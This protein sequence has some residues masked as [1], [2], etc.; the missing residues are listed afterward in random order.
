M[1]NV[2]TAHNLISGSR[3]L[4]LQFNI[5]ADGTGDYSDYE[6]LNLD[7]Y[8]PPDGSKDWTD[9]KVMK[10]TW[11]TGDGVSFQLKFGST[12]DDHRLFFFTPAAYA[13]LQDW[14]DTGGI[15]SNLNTFDGTVRITTSG[16]GTADDELSM[17]LWMQKKLSNFKS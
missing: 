8:G 1:A 13:G 2:I 17:T 9:L 10:A 11:A 12:L 5:V 14:T 4:I 3:N 16:F 15:S 7:N 6:L